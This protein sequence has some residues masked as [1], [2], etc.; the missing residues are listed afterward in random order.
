MAKKRQAHWARALGKK[1]EKIALEKGPIAALKCIHS[2]ESIP[3]LI[4]GGSNALI[5]DQL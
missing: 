4:V 1:C 5:I 3:S 2:T